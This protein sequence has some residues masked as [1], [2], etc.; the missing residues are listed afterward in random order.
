MTTRT[1]PRSAP[2]NG[3]RTRSSAPMRSTS[4]TGQ[5]PR[6]TRPGS[7]HVAMPELSRDP[8]PREDAGHPARTPPPAR[9]HPGPEHPALPLR[10]LEEPR[11]PHRPPSRQVR[12]NREDRLDALPRLT[13]QGRTAHHLPS[14]VRRRCRSTGSAAG[15]GPALPHPR[16]RQARP[17]REEVPGR[18]PQRHRSPTVQ[19]PHRVG[20]RRDTAHHP[21]RVRIH[22]RRRPHRP[23]HAQP[24]RSP[25]ALPGRN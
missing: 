6:S 19:H 7:R 1:G 17:K 3:S 18:D 14:L 5:P 22:E 15:L 11:G 12:L 20:E 23:G 8:N 16:V 25:P 24:R 21:H 13:A 9:L 10:A 2:P 4:S